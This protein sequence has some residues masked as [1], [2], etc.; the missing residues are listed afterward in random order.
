M[1]KKLSAKAKTILGI[2]AVAAVG[3]VVILIIILSTNGAGKNNLQPVNAPDAG[4]SSTDTGND[5][6]VSEPNSTEDN[7][8]EVNNDVP[9]AKDNPNTDDTELSDEEVAAFWL[10]NAGYWFSTLNPNEFDDAVASDDKFIGFFKED[11]VYKFEY[12]L[13]RSSFWIGGEVIKVDSVGEFSV[14]LTLLIQATPETAVDIARPE[15][16]EIIFIHEVDNSINVRIENLG[17]GDC[18][19]YEYAGMTLE[20]VA[21]NH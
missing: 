5:S 12:G 4:T 9:V 18:H 8:A 3:A 10:R 15:R 13:Y 20:E 21:E 16:T 7:P 14:E 1:L 6:S 19:T 17:S 2:T 11:G